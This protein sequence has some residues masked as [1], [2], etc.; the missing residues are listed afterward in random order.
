M[1]GCFLGDSRRY[2]RAI[3]LACVGSTVALL[4]HSV[5][6]FNLQIPANAL[7]FSVVLGIGYKAACLEPSVEQP[8]EASVGGLHVAE[9]VLQHG[10]KGGSLDPFQQRIWRKSD[11]GSGATLTSSTQT[12]PAI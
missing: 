10:G 5:M 8:V 11:H 4:V 12:F 3:V 9:K 2:R 6:D 7:I 1:I